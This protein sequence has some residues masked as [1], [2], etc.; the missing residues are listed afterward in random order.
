V[1]GAIMPDNSKAD[2]VEIT[3]KHKKNIKELME[4]IQCPK[5]FQCYKSGFKKLTKVKPLADG[6]LFECL[7]LNPPVCGFSLPFGDTHFCLCDLRKY[8]AKNFNL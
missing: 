8:I 5:D 2:I 4:K 6:R 3:E 7:A 1:G